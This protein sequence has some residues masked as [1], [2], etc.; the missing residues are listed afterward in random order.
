MNKQELINNLPTNWSQIS[1]IQYINLIKD[2]PV[3]K[4]ENETDNRFQ[5]KILSVFFY[6]FN[7]VNIQDAE[8]NATEMM[9]VIQKIN[10]FNENPD[11]VNIDKYIL[12]DIDKID[13]NTFI[14]LVKYLEMGDVS[15]YPAMLNLL[16]VTPIEDIEDM[17]MAVAYYLIKDLKK[18]LIQ[19]LDI[20]L[21]S[22]KT[23]IQLLREKEQLQKIID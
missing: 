20:S 3:E 2:L 17:N 8:L 1:L 23:Q 10:A 21:T 9:Q 12:K 5:A 15:Y 18:K 19:Y 16:L 11:D 4:L 13:Y 7:N 6:H 22:L 14:T